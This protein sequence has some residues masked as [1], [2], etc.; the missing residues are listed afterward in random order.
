MIL[1]ELK[2]DKDGRAP[3]VSLRG[4]FHDMSLA[5]FTAAADR[6]QLVSPWTP[7]TA[8]R[9]FFSLMAGLFLSWALDDADGHPLVPDGVDAIRTF[10]VALGASPSPSPRITRGKRKATPARARKT[11]KK[12]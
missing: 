6:G 2:L 10:M 11:G 3:D 9:A 7:R 5:I 8:A 12:K 1:V 4:R